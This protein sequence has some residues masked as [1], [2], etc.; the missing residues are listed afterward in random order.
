MY[1]VKRDTQNLNDHIFVKNSFTDLA[2]LFFIDNKIVPYPDG[3]TVGS[4]HW[5]GN[6]S[7]FQNSKQSPYRQL[8]KAFS[9]ALLKRRISQDSWHQHKSKIK[10]GTKCKFLI[11][12]LAKTTS[13]DAEVQTAMTRWNFTQ[14][15]IRNSNIYKSSKSHNFLVVTITDDKKQIRAHLTLSRSGQWTLVISV[16]PRHYS[17]L[18]HTSAIIISSSEYTHTPIYALLVS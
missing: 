9:V 2:Q 10:K 18:P 7:C 3:V 6:C 13:I 11:P 15:R 1:N 14:Q 17:P 8:R 12:V 16:S 4:S 5:K